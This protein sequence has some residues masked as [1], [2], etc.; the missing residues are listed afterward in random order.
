MGWGE[1][2]WMGWG[3]RGGGEG[4]GRRIGECKRLME[5]PEK[6]E[7]MREGEKKRPRECLRPWGVRVLVHREGEEGGSC[8]TFLPRE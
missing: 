2:E 6:G 8:T 3:G 1:G 5:R 7:G 4:N